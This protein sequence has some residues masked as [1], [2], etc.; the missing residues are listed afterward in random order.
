MM[1]SPHTTTRIIFYYK[2]G[3]VIIKVYVIIENS[4]TKTE[5]KSLTNQNNT[6]DDHVILG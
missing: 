5:D 3:E 4:K 1:L 2:K 6:N